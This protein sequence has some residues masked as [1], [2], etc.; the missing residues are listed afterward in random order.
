MSSVDAEVRVSGMG[1]DARRPRRGWCCLSLLLVLTGCGSGQ[2]ALHA[3]TGTVRF[4]GQPA[5][6]FAV[7]FSSEDAPTQGVSAVG[8]ADP[9]GHFVLE[10]RQAGRQK[11]G[12][13]AGRHR[14]VVLPPPAFGDAASTILPVPLRYADYETSGLTADV[15]P[16]QDNKVLLN[17][18]R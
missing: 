11:R 14:V 6:G 5:A 8:V 10:T 12:A 7:E 18:T 17:L 13:V 15:Q 16:S 3:V 1:T 2:P 9:E 4:E